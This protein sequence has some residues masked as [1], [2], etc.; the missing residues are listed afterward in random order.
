MAG[1][2][3]DLLPGV[4]DHFKFTDGLVGHSFVA[5]A[6][7]TSSLIVFIMVHLLGEDGWIFNRPRSF[8]LWNGSVAGYVVLMTIA[9]WH[10]G[11]N[12]AFTIVP[13]FARNTLYVLRLLT[14]VLMLAA[15]VDWLVDAT[16]LLEDPLSLEAAQLEEKT[17]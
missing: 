5:M 4:L 15:S 12:P 2:E 7:F 6:G 3:K 17:A 16:R 13:G 1:I 10:E 14:G 8:Y 9:G 11:F